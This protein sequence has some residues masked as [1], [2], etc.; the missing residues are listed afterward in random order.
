M[1]YYTAIKRDQ[2]TDTCYNMD[3]PWNN[4]V[5]EISQTKKKSHISYDSIYMECPEIGK[6]VETE[7][8][9]VVTK[10]LSECGMGSYCLMDTVS[11]GIM[12]KF[13]NKIVT[14]I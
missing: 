14:T 5:S 1:E 3:K 2:S 7:S 13:W 8:R 10:G 9:L 11:F 4:I 6:S 12:E